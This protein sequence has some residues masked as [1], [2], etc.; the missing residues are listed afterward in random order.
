MIFDVL[1]IFYSGWIIYCYPILINF[2][3]WIQDQKNPVSLDVCP[4]PHIF[5]LIC[6]WNSRKISVVYFYFVTCALLFRRWQ[7]AEL[8]FR[9]SLSHSLWAVLLRTR[10]L[11]FAFC[12]QLCSW[13]ILCIDNWYVFSTVLIALKYNTVAFCHQLQLF[14]ILCQFENYWINWIFAYYGN[15][16]IF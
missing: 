4:V 15:I 16:F 9:A 8:L 12:N 13:I 11:N 7:F 1:L 14:F 2:L 5:L 10:Y 3:W 6:D